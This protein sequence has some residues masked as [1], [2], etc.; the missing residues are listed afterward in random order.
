LL[1]PSDQKNDMKFPTGTPGATFTDPRN[2]GFAR[3][4]RTFRGAIDIT[5]GTGHGVI[6][7]DHGRLIAAYFEDNNGRFQG[8]DALARLSLEGEGDDLPQTFRLR[9][10]TP[11]E[12]NLAVQTSRDESLLLAPES[13]PP[14]PVPGQEEKTPAGP[15]AHPDEASLKKILDQ[16]GV[17]AVSAFFEGFPVRSLGVA[18]FEHVAA[19]AEDFARAGTR[20]AQEMGIGP[21]DQLILET[22]RNKFIIAPCGDLYLCIFTR[23]D[24]QLGLIPVILKS[25]QQ[26][27]AN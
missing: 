16:P 11:E 27:I 19:S 7:T 21:L 18:D 25:I 14:I 13:S 17:L 22:S 2:E 24:A 10:Y 1:L 9:S 3:D 8:K 12:F 15:S 4:R 26:E 6:L 23:A 5:T 20:V